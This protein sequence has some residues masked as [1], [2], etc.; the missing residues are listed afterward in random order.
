MLS[1]IIL[2]G[3]IVCLFGIKEKNQKIQDTFSSETV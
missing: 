2:I 1:V 3:G